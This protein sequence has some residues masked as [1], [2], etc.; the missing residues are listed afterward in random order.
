MLHDA[1]SS[2]TVDEIFGL[3]EKELKS[4][5]LLALGDGDEINDWNYKLKK[6]VKPLRELVTAI[7]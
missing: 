6:V 3:K 5:T 7:K 1:S 2:A 4:A